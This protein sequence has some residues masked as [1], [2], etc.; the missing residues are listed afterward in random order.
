MSCNGIIVFFFQALLACLGG[1]K[2]YLL[3]A[4]HFKFFLDPS[5]EQQ[6]VPEMGSAK[7]SGQQIK[8]VQ[9]VCLQRMH[10]DAEQL[11]EDITGFYSAG[12][13]YQ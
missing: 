8:Q 9:V 3:K 13:T 12:S 4:T 5:R 6:V 7:G 11:G 1:Q 10:F 2:K